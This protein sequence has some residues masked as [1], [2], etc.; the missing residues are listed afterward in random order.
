MMAV[1]TRGFPGFLVP[2]L[3]EGI[4]EV[5]LSYGLLLTGVKIIPRFFD[6]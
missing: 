6:M 1:A 5:T 3:P 2:V 4:L